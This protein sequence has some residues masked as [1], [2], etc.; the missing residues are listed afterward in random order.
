MCDL[1]LA[2]CFYMAVDEQDFT[3]YQCD[4]TPLWAPVR[5]IVGPPVA[6]LGGC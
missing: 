1:H 6:T 4:L 5:H 3:T 2:I